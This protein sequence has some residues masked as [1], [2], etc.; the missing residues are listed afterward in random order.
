MKKLFTL[1][2]AAVMALAAN[3]AEFTGDMSVAL[4]GGEPLVTPDTKIIVEEVENSDGL[5][6][7]TL[8][9]F[10]YSV[11]S[12][13]DL[14]IENVKGDDDTDGF[15]WF[16]ETKASLSVNIGMPI[17]AD[18]TLKEGSVMKGENLYLDLS[19]NAVGMEITAVFGD[20]S[21]AP[22]QLFSKEFTDDLTVTVDMQGTGGTMP[23]QKATISVKEQE[24]G[25][26]T[27]SLKNFELAGVMSVGTVEMKDVEGTEEDG[28]IVMSTKQTVTIQAG[29][30][31]DVTWALEGIPV[32][33]DMTA[34]MTDDK[35]IADLNI[36]YDMSGRGDPDY[37]MHIKVA[38]GYIPSGISGVTT[39]PDNGEEAIYDLSGRR[40]NE[41]Q[42][43][44]NIVRKADGT[45]VKVLKK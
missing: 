15:T 13:G 36:D 30:D 29:D 5:Y 27:L 31:P 40:L 17:Q 9:D 4:G 37:I 28:N 22:A 3:A 18:V 39:T 41:M 7:I 1:F 35:L 45:T 16:E 38:F 10:S 21:F 14:K 32:D 34:T 2:A 26:Y 24:D 44:I 11:L 20:N 33:V 43:G 19:I 25:K 12:L 42:K 8:K 23:A 6:N